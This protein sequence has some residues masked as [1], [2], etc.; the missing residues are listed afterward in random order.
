L[1]GALHL[2][3]YCHA[4]REKRSA[5]ALLI[6]CIAGL[7]SGVRKRRDTAVSLLAVSLCERRVCRMIPWDHAVL[8]GSQTRSTGRQEGSRDQVMG[9]SSY[10]SLEFRSLEC[11]SWPCRCSEKLACPENATFAGLGRYKKYSVVS[12]RQR[13][14]STCRLKKR[15]VF[16]T[17]RFLA[18]GE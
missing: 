1:E 4:S 6:V 10:A 9:V 15:A 5:L 14:V 2:V 7:D 16:I 3:E 18:C 11:P 8:T 12:K 17:C 13:H